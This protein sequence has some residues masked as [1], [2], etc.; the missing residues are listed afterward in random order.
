MHGALF[1]RLNTSWCLIKYYVTNLREESSPEEANSCSVNNFTV[2]YGTRSFITVFT[3]VYCPERGECSPHHHTLLLWDPLSFHLR[4]GFP[5]IFF[6]S[7][8]LIRT[9]CSHRYH[10]CHM[11]SPSHPFHM[12]LI[13]IFS[14]EYNLWFL[15]S[16][17]FS[18]EHRK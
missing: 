10:V 6:P 4:L 13:I 16:T 7:R 1:L 15:L 18:H 3:E 12:T 9:L 8:L 5:D 14:G 2:F 11:P 17:L